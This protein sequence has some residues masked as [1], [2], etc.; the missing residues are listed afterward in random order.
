MKRIYGG[1]GGEENLCGKKN[2]G[3]ESSV[4]EGSLAKKNSLIIN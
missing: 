4:D 1:G 2:I 3:L